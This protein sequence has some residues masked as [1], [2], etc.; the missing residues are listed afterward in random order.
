[1]LRL[2]T[3]KLSEDANWLYELK[4]DEFR[5]LAIKTDGRVCL[6]SRNNNNFHFALP[7]GRK[8]SGAHPE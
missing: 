1:M 5:A 8:S 7:G 6:K 2:R 4:Y 3:E